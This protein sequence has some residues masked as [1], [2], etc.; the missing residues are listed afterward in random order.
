M[1]LFWGPVL[2]SPE[3]TLLVLGVHSF[4]GAGNGI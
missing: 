3:P 1:N 4:D 2:R